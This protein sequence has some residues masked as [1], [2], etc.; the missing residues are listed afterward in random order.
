[1]RAALVALYAFK[2]AALAGLPVHLQEGA[3]AVLGEEEAAALAAL[4]PERRELVAFAFLEGLSHQEIAARTRLPLGTVKSHV[5]RGLLQ[6]RE[7]LEAER[8]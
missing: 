7:A 1:M 3:R 6:L 5:C 2:R 8:A 4:P